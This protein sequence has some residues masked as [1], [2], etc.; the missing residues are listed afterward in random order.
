MRPGAIWI[1][2][3][4]LPRNATTHALA[5]SCMGHHA[6]P[7]RAWLGLP[8]YNADPAFT[9]ANALALHHPGG[10]AKLVSFANGRC[11]R[12]QLAAPAP[13]RSQP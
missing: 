13:S 4:D 10:S 6:A 12:S 1:A 9:P 3:S 2:C 5:R 8:G 11:G 7:E